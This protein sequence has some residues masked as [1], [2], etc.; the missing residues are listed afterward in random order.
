MKG[1]TDIGKND[2]RFLFVL[3]VMV[4]DFLDEERTTYSLGRIGV[5]SLLILMDLSITTFFIESSEGELFQTGYFATDS[6]NA[7]QN[8]L[9]FLIPNQHV[10]GNVKTQIQVL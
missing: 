3:V 1:H 9:V 8:S 7:L 4:V 5:L 6:Y 2:P 10:K